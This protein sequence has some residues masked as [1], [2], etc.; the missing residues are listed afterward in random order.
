[1]RKIVLDTDF[2]SLPCDTATLEEGEQ[3]AQELLD[4]MPDYAVGIAANQIG[5]QKRVCVVD[6]DETII[7]INPVITH[8][9]GEITFREGCLSFP[10]KYI[11]TKRFASITVEADNH[12]EP[13]H[14]S[15]KNTL[16]CVCVQHEIDHLNG[17]TMFERE[18]NKQY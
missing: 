13:L 14:F 17:I 9:E 3:I 11:L 15:T 6:V 18:Y 16:E 5:I 7:L 4:S 1:M 8:S 12:E 10:Q 2:L